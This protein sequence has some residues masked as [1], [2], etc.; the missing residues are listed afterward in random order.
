[1]K[2]VNFPIGTLHST[3]E[4]P[5]AIVSGDLIHIV[6]PNGEIEAA[7]LEQIDRRQTKA[8]LDKCIVWGRIGEL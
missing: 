7:T 6:Y 8:A 5:I 2:Q 1:M 4:N 3:Q